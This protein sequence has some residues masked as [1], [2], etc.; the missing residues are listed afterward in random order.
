MFG[1]LG[2]RRV[3]VAAVAAT[4]VAGATV[5]AASADKGHKGDVGDSTATPIKH[6]VV[7]FQENVSFDHYFATYPQTQRAAGDQ[8]FSARS[9]TP[10]ING[11]NTPLLAPNNPNSIQPCLLHRSQAYT[12]D[13]G[14]G[15]TAEQ[16]A[17]DHGLMDKFPEFTGSQSGNP[18]C[19]YG[20]GKGLVMGYY[21][22]GTTTALWNYARR[23]SRGVGV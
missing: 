23:C 21:D 7:I 10:S 4:A 18:G 19:D 15:Y 16:L 12:C 17:F 20:H 2:W 14:H 3:A 6:L 8:P 13:Q 5:A 9:N 22:G 11:L 1:S